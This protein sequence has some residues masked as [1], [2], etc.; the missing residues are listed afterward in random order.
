VVNPRAWRL[1]LIAPYAVRVWRGLTT[2][3]FVL[4]Q[5]LKPMTGPSDDR[6]KQ[7]FFLSDKI[8][9]RWVD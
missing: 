7:S 5:N 3:S 2:A 9:T 6:D 8:L 4:W 1:R